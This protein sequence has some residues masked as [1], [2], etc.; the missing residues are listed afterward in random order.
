[1]KKISP[2]RY[3][4]IILALL[5][6]LSS[7]VKKDAAYFLEQA[8]VAYKE[9]KTDEAIL[10]YKSGI[11]LAPKN[12]VLREELGLI[13]SKTGEL[14]SSLKEL[15][16]AVQHGKINSQIF[17]KIIE[18]NF[19]LE[20][21]LYISNFYTAHIAEL[22]KEDTIPATILTAIS[23]KRLGQTQASGT[24]I[25]QL[26]LSHP[27]IHTGMVKYLHN[28]Y[29]AAFEALKKST[30]YLT[31]NTG[32]T[33]VLAQL[34]SAVSDHEYSLGLYRKVS[35]TIPN[36]LP[37]Q[38]FL[39]NSLVLQNSI[40]EATPII[41]KLIKG[42]PN[43]SYINYLSSI[44][45]IKRNDIEGAK[46]AAE[47]AIANGFNTSQARSIAG[48][49]NY[50]LG[51]YESAYKNLEFIENSATRDGFVYGIYLAASIELGYAVDS[52]QALTQ[53]ESSE[54]TSKLTAYFTKQLLVH[55]DQDLINSIIVEKF[56]NANLELNKQTA[57]AAI[58]LN[59]RTMDSRLKAYVL[60]HLDDDYLVPLYVAQQLRNRQIDTALLVARKWQSLSPK[61]LVTNQTL[62]AILSA[63]GNTVEA[64]ENASETLKLFPDD[65]PSLFLLKS[66]EAKGK[67]YSESKSLLAPVF[68]ISSAHLASLKL[69]K[70]KVANLAEMT[71]FVSFLENSNK[72]TESSSSYVTNTLYDLQLSLNRPKS[73]IE[74]LLMT[75]LQQLDVKKVIL[76]ARAYL[77]NK[78]ANKAKDILR[79]K[80]EM[81]PGSNELFVALLSVQASN[82]EFSS[83]FNNIDKKI[84]EVERD[85]E[86]QIV[87]A[88]YQIVSGDVDAALR[89]IENIEID[90][91][92]PIAQLT[93]IEMLQG[94]ILYI[95]KQY[96]DSIPGLKKLYVAQKDTPSIVM[97]FW[98]HFRTKKIAE[99]YEI[100]NNHVDI[101]PG[102]LNT[103]SFAAE[104]NIG[105]NNE[106]AIQN[107]LALYRFNPK[108]P[109]TL[110]NLSFAYRQVKDF[111][112]AIKYS[113]E[114]ISIV[115]NDTNIMDTHGMNLLMKGD[116][117]EA[118][119]IMKNAY[120]L[121]KEEGIGINYGQTLLA[122]E[123]YTEATKLI[124][125]LNAKSDVQQQ[126]ID[127]LKK[128]I[129]DNQ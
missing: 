39:A 41:E 19:F 96:E 18:N 42:Y 107:Y 114:A 101:F 12:A 10:Q 13:Y 37:F 20:S 35:E 124:E 40:D 6:S 118:E 88:D 1:M 45:H 57:I 69:L 31:E 102:D 125:Q 43:H 65:L 82:K 52:F 3:L 85:I 113:A 110:N 103:V 90:S 94:K 54:K 106:L 70:D 15:E 104:L 55:G 16:L 30:A 116:K 78:E 23:L 77:Q 76:L 68:A 28:D 47:K 72:Q 38:L 89:T 14:D 27:D 119:K 122:N 33:L 25:S 53:A 92:T 5:V 112:N 17:Y 86:L 46:A 121:S 66:L 67:S 29:P 120:F 11:G 59:R 50:F 21:D 9:G 87:K 91:S 44:L 61:S 117:V 63:S 8:R 4:A 24:L 34:A 62:S 73:V 123:K 60:E 100:L 115:P 109:T 36:F 48:I 97:L 80:L 98:A 79:R 127:M 49:A 71:D 128:H 75:P 105:F 7:C 56:E 81:A 83:V 74:Q 51:N 108:N 126:Q 2:M 111:D 64:I 93:M 32:T 84:L 26:E 99:A 58:V 129:Q 22:A 95:K